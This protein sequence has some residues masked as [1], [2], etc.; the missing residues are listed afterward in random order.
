MVAQ[1]WLKPID[2]M[3]TNVV[4]Q[5]SLLEA[6]RLYGKLKKYI[7]FSTPEVYGN[8]DDW[9]N[10]S[11]SFNPS[12]PYASSRA[13]GDTNT[14]I[15]SKSYDIPVL[16]TRAAN[17]YCEGQH[18]YRIIPRTILAALNP[19][20][21]TIDGNGASVRSFIH[22]EDVCTLLELALS[23]DKIYDEFHISPRQTIIIRDLVKLIFDMNGVSMDDKKH[24]SYGPERKG[25]DQSYLLDS[26]KAENELGWK[27]KITIQE[28]VEKVLH[29][30]KNNEPNDM[31]LKYIH[32]A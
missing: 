8:T 6:I 15:W 13:F 4:G 1:S 14:K 26:S 3:Q 19:N 16:I 31:P 25:K 27:P 5:T 20:P 12:T 28:G 2:W 21:L 11:T 23:K 30:Y 9:V 7:H 17:I 32:K 10:E 24:I 29:W 18:L 22:M